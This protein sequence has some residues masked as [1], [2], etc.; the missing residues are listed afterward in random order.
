MVHTQITDNGEGI[1]PS[2]INRIF[3]R[4][5]SAKHSVP[6]GIGLHW[7][8]NTIAKMNGRIYAESEGKGC[9]ACFHLLLPSSS[10]TTSVCSAKG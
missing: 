6:A 10:K 4:A 3:E 8:A 7:C 5:F 1:E 2:N 9:G